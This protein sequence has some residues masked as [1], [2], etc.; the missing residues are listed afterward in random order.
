[1]LCALKIKQPELNVLMRG[2]LRNQCRLVHAVT[3]SI[4]VRSGLM[5]RISCILD[6]LNE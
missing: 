3:I 2:Y 4:G 1:M 6:C 5:C